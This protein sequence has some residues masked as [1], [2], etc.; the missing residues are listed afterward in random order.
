VEVHALGGS[1][2]VAGREAGDFRF[3]CDLLLGKFDAKPRN[4]LEAKKSKKR[5]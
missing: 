5:E 1:L 4:V 2:G 3:F